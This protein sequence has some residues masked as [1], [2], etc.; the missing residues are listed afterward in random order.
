MS[1]TDALPDLSGPYP[2]AASDRDAFARDGH[3]VL[4][5]VAS[6]AEVAP[7]RQ[8]IA[9]GV[10]RL[11]GESRPLAE[12]DTYGRAFLQVPNLWQQDEHVARFVQASRFARLAAG[13]LGVEAVRLYHDQALFKEPGGGPTPWHQDGIYW[14]LETDRTVTMWM[15][16][17][18]VPAGMEWVSGSHHEGDLGRFEIS[19]ASEA[20]FQSVVAARGL[21]VSAAGPLRAGDATFHAGWV[22][23]RAPGNETDTMREVMTVIWFADG[24]RVGAADSASRR[25]DLQKWLPGLAPGDLAASALNPRLPR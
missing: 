15:P 16:L 5:A 22:L 17:V 13:L 19:D 6:A 2:L 23:H 9:G 21:P 8:A 3:V 14:P 10:T 4:R 11:S 12:R 7:Y 25:R 24:T 18:D 1:V 20:H